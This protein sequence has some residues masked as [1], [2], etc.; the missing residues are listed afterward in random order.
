LFRDGRLA[1][2]LQQPQDFNGGDVLL[3][4]LFQTTFA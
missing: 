4:L 3:E 1:F 2:G